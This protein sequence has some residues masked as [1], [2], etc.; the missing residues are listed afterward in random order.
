VA[1]KFVSR[2]TLRMDERSEA[3]NAF[4]LIFNCLETIK[5][6]LTRKGQVTNKFVYRLS[7]EMAERSETKN[8]RSN[9]KQE[10]NLYFDF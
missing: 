1:N 3:K 5:T 8:A 2:I 9:A 7:L 6:E 4:L 10:N